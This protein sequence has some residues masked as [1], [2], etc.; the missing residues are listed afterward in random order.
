[1][2]LPQRHS[3]RTRSG[4]PV[5]GLRSTAP[6]RPVRVTGIASTS[7]RSTASGSFP[8]AAH[9]PANPVNQPSR[10]RGCGPGA[11]AGTRQSGTR[12]RP[13]GPPRPM[14]IGGPGDHRCHRRPASTADEPLQTVRLELKLARERHSLGA[15]SLNLARGGRSLGAVSFK[16]AFS[17]ASGSRRTS[18]TVRAEGPSWLVRPALPRRP[19]WSRPP[20][21]GGPLRS[22]RS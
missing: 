5:G 19:P 21:R 3:G 2:P 12:P 16:L 10:Q 13:A 14:P 8:P 9:H 6:G 7:A 11:R 4:S 17:L 18:V 1:V 15:V 20:P 22:R